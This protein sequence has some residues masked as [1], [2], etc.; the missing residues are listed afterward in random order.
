MTIDESTLARTLRANGIDVDEVSVSPDRVAV[1][2][3]TTLPGAKPDHGEIGRVCNAFIDL[4][5]DDVLDP[6]RVE[7]TA[8]RF[9]D[10]V[11]ATWHVDADWFADLTS[12]RISEEDFSARVIG[13]IA[14]DPDVETPAADGGDR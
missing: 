8:L 4:V 13:T 1:A 14:T 3:T 5:E 10:D 9:A 12:Y 6:T 2:Y 7:A 11:Q